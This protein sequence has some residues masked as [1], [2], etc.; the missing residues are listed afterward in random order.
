MDNIADRVFTETTSDPPADNPSLLTVILELTPKS[1]A[2]LDASLQD[3]VKALVVFLNAHLSLNNSNQVAF[4]VS[5]HVGARFLHPGVS[6]VETETRFVNPGMYHQF[7]LVDEAV[8]GAL[9][10]ELERLAL[11]AKNDARSTLAGALLMAM[12]YTN[13][14]LHVD[15]S[16]SAVQ[17]AA[18]GTAGA[19][20]TA[21]MGA[22]V[23][24]VSANESDDNNYMGIMNAIFAAQKMKVAIDVAKLGRRSAPYLEQAADATQGVYLHV[25]DPR[26][27]VQTLAT[28]FF[29]EPLLR[30]VVILPTHGNVDYKASCFLTGR[31]VDVGYVCLVCLCIMS[32][33]PDLGACPMCHSQFD[34]HHIARLRRGPLVRKRRKMEETKA[35]ETK[36]KA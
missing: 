2:A 30:L 17:V 35:E 19:Q 3:I 10:K 18:A 21:A 27:M 4:L 25:A 29:V 22:R 36:A 28:A 14:M 33:L 34:E 13:R 32:M 26:G 9:N 20:T 24:V 5:L 15:Q 23:L 31:A 6:D 16:G 1:I 8:F 11:A 12:T 7:R